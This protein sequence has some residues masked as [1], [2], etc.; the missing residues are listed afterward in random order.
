M[1]QVFTVSS[2]INEVQIDAKLVF[3][4]QIEAWFRRRKI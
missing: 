4:Y 1:K 3:K 2:R